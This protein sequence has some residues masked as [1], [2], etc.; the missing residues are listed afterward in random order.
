L[1]VS[2]SKFAVLEFIFLFLILNCYFLNPYLYSSGFVLCSYRL[3]Y[4]TPINSINDSSSSIK[5]K[6][7]SPNGYVYILLATDLINLWLISYLK[8]YR[9]FSSE[10]SNT[11]LELIKLELFAVWDAKSEAIESWWLTN[12]MSFIFILKKLLL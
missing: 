4:S 6:P 11:R 7:S 10:S 2:R 8:S 9:L 3:Y 1:I 5:S 12:Y